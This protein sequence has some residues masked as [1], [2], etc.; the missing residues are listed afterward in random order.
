MLETKATNTRLV[1]IINIAP[2]QQKWL[3]ER[4]SKLQVG[5][6]AWFFIFVCPLNLHRI[7][8]LFKKS[9]TMC[10]IFPLCHCPILRYRRRYVNRRMINL[11]K[12]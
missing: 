4:A 8:K 3:C 1:C 6:F 5:H 2:R 9:V 7:L 12:K 11:K 10:F